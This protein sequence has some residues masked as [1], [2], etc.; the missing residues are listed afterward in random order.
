M[1]SVNNNFKIDTRQLWGQE[2]YLLNMLKNLTVEDYSVNAILTT[3]GFLL[4]QTLKRQLLVV[5]KK[6]NLSNYEVNQT[7]II[8]Q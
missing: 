3:F 7:W 1:F 2:Q 8:I 5:K 4:H 6:K